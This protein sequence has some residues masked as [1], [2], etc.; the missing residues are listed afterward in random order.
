MLELSDLVPYG[1]RLLVELRDQPEKV[2]EIWL[3][4][5][6]DK[7]DIAPRLAKVLALPPGYDQGCVCEQCRGF[8]RD[9]LAHRQEL[10]PGDTVL[11]QIHGGTAVDLR[12]ASVDLTK[13][14]T[15]TPP[16]KGL[17]VLLHQVL[18]VVP[19]PKV[20]AADLKLQESLGSRPLTVSADDLR[21]QA[22][23]AMSGRL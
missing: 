5:A 18:A 10:V 15:R 9:G 19:G 12:G 4:D 21:K 14:G 23:Q 1:E 3:P 13:H 7:R 6:A 16:V 11:L 8:H 22:M 2:G 20:T 17:L